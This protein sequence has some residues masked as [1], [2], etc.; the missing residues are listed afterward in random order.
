MQAVLEI[1][2][3][4]HEIICFLDAICHII[5]FSYQEDPGGGGI[6]LQPLQLGDGWQEGWQNQNFLA[7]KVSSKI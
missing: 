7:H 6:I 2:L 5:I 3:F 4:V 1:Q